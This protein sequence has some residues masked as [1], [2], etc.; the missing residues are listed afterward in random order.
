M[1]KLRY[2]LKL[3]DDA[4]LTLGNRLADELPTMERQ[5]LI[6]LMRLCFDRGIII[7]TLEAEKF[8]EILLRED[9][10]DC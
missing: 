7:H 4:I 2:E 9:E 1:K 8:R 3:T 5:K 10:D 6:T